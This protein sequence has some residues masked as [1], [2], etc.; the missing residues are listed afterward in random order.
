MT[1]QMSPIL[2]ADG[3]HLDPKQVLRSDL[4]PV[5]GISHENQWNLFTADLRFTFIV[6]L[7][8]ELLIKS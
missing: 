5:I 8:A 3:S 2:P 4:S 1:E 7:L 6:E